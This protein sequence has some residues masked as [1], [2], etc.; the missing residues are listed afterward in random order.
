MIYIY[1]KNTVGKAEESVLVWIR[2]IFFHCLHSLQYRF[3]ERAFTSR[4]GLHSSDVFFSF[5]NKFDC[6]LIHIQFWRSF[7]TPRAFVTFRYCAKNQSPL[8]TCS[9]QHLATRYTRNCSVQLRSGCLSKEKKYCFN[10]V[11]LTTTK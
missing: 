6:T 11:L 7:W 1:I 2:K 4:D 10:L 9:H 5:L 3:G 8:S